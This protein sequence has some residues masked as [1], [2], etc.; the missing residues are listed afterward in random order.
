MNGHDVTDV[1]DDVAMK[2]LRS[3]PKRLKMVL[4][5]AVQNLRAPPSPDSLPDITL[6]KTATGQLGT[7][8]ALWGTIY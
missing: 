4:G 7:E 3:S 6:Y 2:I 5:R 1:T 8:V